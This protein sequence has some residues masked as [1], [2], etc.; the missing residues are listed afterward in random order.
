MSPA[1]LP[2]NFQLLETKLIWI[3]DRLLVKS[4]KTNAITVE[5]IPAWLVRQGRLVVVM[6]NERIEA[7]VGHWMFPRQGQGWVHTLPNSKILSVHFRLRWP[8]GQEVYRRRQTLV[9]PAQKCPELTQAATHLLN[10]LDGET[11]WYADQWAPAS[12]IDYFAMQSHF[13]RWL[14][15]YG[16]IMEAHG[17]T[18]ITVNDVTAPAL[19]AWKVLMDWDLAKPFSRKILS[20][21]LGLSIP[22]LSRRFTAYYGATPRGFLE[23]R[24][25]EWA[26][27]RLAQSQ[28]R[29][30]VI[31]AELGFLNL[32]QFSNW[33]RLHNQLSPRDYRNFAKGI[34]SP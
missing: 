13:Q 14:A 22:A 6:G 9:L 2:L 17:E 31:A 3:Q 30:K 7:G 19:E 4:R 33:F 25:L 8:N 26:Q 10:H 29:I 21:H 15:A 16:S 32:A 20:R 28:E 27:Q 1:L 24:K 23:Q 11:M 34:N 18:Q 5:N 12:C